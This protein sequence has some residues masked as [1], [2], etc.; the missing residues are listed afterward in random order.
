MFK[1]MFTN[2]NTSIK[3]VMAFIGFLL[4]CITMVLNSFSHES[5]KPSKELVDAVTF[6]IIFCIGGNV[7]EKF[8]K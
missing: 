3:R 2:G 1:D 8:K 7:I 6:V 5:I 4:L